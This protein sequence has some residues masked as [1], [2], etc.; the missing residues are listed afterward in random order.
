MTVEL[1]DFT[2]R[3]IQSPVINTVEGALDIQVVTEHLEWVSQ[4]GSP[5]AYAPH[6]RKAPLAGM[7]AKSVLFQIA[8]GDQ[9]ANNPSTTAIL[10]AGDLVDST[11]YYL[12]D[13]ARAE[14]PGVPANP[15]TFVTSV[16]SPNPTYR[17]I[18][19]G[20]QDQAGQF[21]FAGGGPVTVPEPSRFFEFPIILPLPEGLNYIIP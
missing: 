20:A 18:A 6:L 17:A 5:L 12:H 9:S 1:A 2:T 4:A 11:L 14:D 7:T 10:R 3:V 21:F 13:L 19:L 8:K 16:T 15:H